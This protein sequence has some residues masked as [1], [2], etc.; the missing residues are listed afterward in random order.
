MHFQEYFRPL[1]KSWR[2][3]LT[4]HSRIMRP[5]IAGSREVMQ[6]RRSIELEQIRLL[7]SVIQLIRR[8][9]ST[10][11]STYTCTILTSI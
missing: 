2:M 10:N 9:M 5:L 1:W 8:S 7:L 6:S 3:Y 4:L 11:Y